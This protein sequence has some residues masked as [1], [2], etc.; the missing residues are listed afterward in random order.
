MSRIE[1]LLKA[2]INNT[3]YDEPRL[4]RIEEIFYSIFYSLPYNAD[5]QSRIEALLLALKESGLYDE[6]TLSRIEEILKCKLDGSTYTGWIGSRVEMLLN[7]WELSEI[8]EATFT[9]FPIIIKANGEPLLD[10]IIYGNEQHTGTPSPDNP[11]TPQ[12]TGE[13]TG[14]LWSNRGFSATR[15]TS[16]HTHTISNNYGTTLSTTEGD[17]VTITQSAYLHQRDYQNGFFMI[18]VDFSKYDVGDVVTISFD[19]I[20]DEIHA[21]YPLTDVYAGKYNNAVPVAL[22]SGD[23]RISGRLTAVITVIAN[24]SPYVEVR[25]RGNSITVKNIMLNTGSTAKPYE[26]YGYKIPISSANTTTPVYLGEVETTRKIRKLVLTGEENVIMPATS[27]FQIFGVIQWGDINGFCTHYPQ[28]TWKEVATKNGFAMRASSDGA[29]RFRI[30][31]L[32]IT[33]VADFKSYLQQQYAAGTPVTVW[34]VLA[35]PETAVVNEP[36]MKIGD[37]A[38]TLSMEQAG[39]SIPTLNKPNNTVIDVE[40]TLKP[41]EMYVKYNG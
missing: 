27:S 33:T 20:V 5:A 11:I 13:R 17:E 23:W 35:T 22:S 15:I 28:I 8:I 26:P 14:N 7:E 32:S 29:D 16:N 37:Y 1:K 4:S 25:L 21:L 31:D 41:S 39:V 19:Y 2:I 36:L 34:Y 24:M 12:G 40:T 9:S 38:D 10:Y 3:T 18:D 30:C 6:R